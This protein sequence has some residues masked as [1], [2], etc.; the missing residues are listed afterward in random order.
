MTSRREQWHELH[1]FA[2]DVLVA[3][4]EVGD[5]AETPYG[6]AIKR[7]LESKYGHEINHGRLYPNLNDLVE[8]GF[9]EKSKVD[10]RTNAYAVTGEGHVL[11]QAGYDEL[12]AVVMADSQRAVA[13]GGRDE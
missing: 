10:D 8:A 11:L 5:T 7:N 2:R 9:V 12:S 1:G 13:D 4:A 6:L 3:A